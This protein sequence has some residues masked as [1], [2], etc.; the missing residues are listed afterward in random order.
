MSRLSRLLSKNHM[1]P[2][3]KVI[4]FCGDVMT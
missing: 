3:R 4:W 2:I 1:R